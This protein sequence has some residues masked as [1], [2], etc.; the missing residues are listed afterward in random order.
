MAE[1]FDHITE[2]APE[3]IVHEQHLG[4]HGLGL[5][6]AGGGGD[7]RHTAAVELLVGVVHG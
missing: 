4:G 5:E 6:H 3:G 2:G 1:Q 7:G